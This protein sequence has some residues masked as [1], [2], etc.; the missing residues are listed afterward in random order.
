MKKLSIFLLT[1]LIIS[2]FG[3]KPLRDFNNNTNEWKPKD[4]DPKVGVLIIQNVELSKGQFTRLEN[5]MKKHYPYKY[6]FAKKTYNNDSTYSDRNTYRFALVPSCKEI[7]AP[8]SNYSS[9]PGTTT[10]F[11]KEKVYDFNFYDRL[12]KKSY[13]RSGVFASIPIS[14]FK[15][16]IKNILKTK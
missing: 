6:E 3:C 5:Y 7:I 1:I 4:F 10:G 12:K 2:G 14:P 8:T 11:R 15:L 9:S 13:S 16:I